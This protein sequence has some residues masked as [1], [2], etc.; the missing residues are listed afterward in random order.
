M[1]E[2]EKKEEKPVKKKKVQF[3]LE[4][5]QDAEESKSVR[6]EDAFDGKKS[7]STG[8]SS[9]NENPAGMS[10][11]KRKLNE[12]RMTRRNMR[13]QRELLRE[14]EK[15]TSEARVMAQEIAQ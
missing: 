7:K 13:K 6:G 12:M 15:K 9:S 14:F 2:E 5:T 4:E 3:D 8:N 11:T 1:V 10:K